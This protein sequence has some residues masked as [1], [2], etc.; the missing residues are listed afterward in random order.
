MIY[1]FLLMVDNYFLVV[2]AIDK[3]M[4]VEETYMVVRKLTSADRVSL[5]KLWSICFMYSINV[6]E[7]E[8]KSNENPAAPTGYG[9]F[10]EDGEMIAGVIGNELTMNFDGS[11][12]P[13]TG[14][15]GVVT[16][17]SYRKGGAIKSIM[18]SLLSEARKNGFVF[19]GLYPFNHGF[20]RKFGYE[21]SRDL[22]TYT[23]AFPLIMKYA[24]DVKTKLLTDK[25]DRTFLHPVYEAFTKRYNLSIDRDKDAFNRATA[26]NP[27]AANDYTYAIYDGNEP[28]AYIAFHKVNSVLNVKDYAFKTEKDFIKI[29][30]FLSRFS[31]EFEKIEIALPS[32]IP[33]ALLSSNPYDVQ[34]SVNSRYMTRVVNCEKAL[35]MLNRNITSPFVI[36]IDDPFLPENSGTFK[37]WSGGCEKTEDKADVRMS[38]Q[39]FSQMIAGYAGFE[40]TLFREDVELFG[41]LETLKAVFPKMATYLGVYY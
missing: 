13:L 27:Y 39:A 12:V 22:E 30:S 29:L 4:Y 10:N 17:P 6:E 15:G 40:G 18:K 14:I 28:C 35:S 9:A 38:I 25:D 7:A 3:K 5:E 36:E 24:G 23:F 34:K 26:S 32:D 33:I 11:K 37:V 31:P 20:Y 2:Y 1:P 16:H 41:N 21:L 19:S 8:K